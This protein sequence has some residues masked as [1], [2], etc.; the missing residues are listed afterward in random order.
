[1]STTL[2]IALS[3]GRILD[4]TLPLLAAAAIMA[5]A[6]PA[7]SRKR[8]AMDLACL[9]GQ[10]PADVLRFRLPDIRDGAL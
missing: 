10:R 4:E 2:M 9:T 7:T 5:S 1:M 6:D 3:K 8:D